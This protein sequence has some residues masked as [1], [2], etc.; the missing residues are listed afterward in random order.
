MILEDIDRI[1][2]IRGPGATVWGA[3]AVNGV[4]NITTN[5]A[6]A[7]QGDTIALFPREW[8][9][10]PASPWLKTAFHDVPWD[11]PATVRSCIEKASPAAKAALR[12]SAQGALTPKIARFS[13]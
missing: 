10:D 12:A 6:S 5:R 2:I 8:L 13:P 9:R 4:I 1:E 3:N 11:D 7:T